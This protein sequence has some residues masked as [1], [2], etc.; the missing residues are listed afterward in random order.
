MN[1]PI[2]VIDICNTL[3]RINEE[4]ERILGVN[5]F[6]NNYL[7]PKITPHFFENH[8]E[9]FTRCVPLSDAR[10]GVMFL[11]KYFQI[12]YLTARPECTREI[13]P[14]WLKRWGFPLAP[15]VITR[16]KL[17]VVRKIGAVFAIDDA[18]HEIEALMKAVPVLVPA[19]KYNYK[20]G[21]ARFV[22]RDIEEVVQ[23]LGLINETRKVS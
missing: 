2:I 15:I 20:M 19:K 18:P 9:I 22:W 16:D 1:K 6:P 8:A 17:A 10:N 7:H 23:R 13:N 3:A 12:V 5:P 14:V 21:T 11:A 4:V